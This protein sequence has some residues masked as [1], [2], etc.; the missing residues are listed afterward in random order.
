MEKITFGG[1]TLSRWK[2]GRS[3][4]LASPE[5][6][7]RLMNWS[8][9]L[10]DGSIRDVI[11]WPENADF[12][13]IAKVRG[14]NPIL[15]PFAGR[16]F[17]DGE[18]NFWRDAAGVRR[19]MPMHGFAR[20]GSF[21]LIRSDARGFA[22]RFLPSAEARAAYPFAYDLTV[23]YRFDAVSL[24]CE[25]ALLNRGTE[26]MPWSPGYHLYFTLPWAE[27]TQRSDYLIR[28]P[29]G[30]RTRQSATGAL[31]PQPAGPAEENLGNP[32]LIDLEFRELR[33][34]EV[35]FGEKGRPGDVVLRHGTADVPHPDATIITW[36]ET[37]TSPFYC[38]EPCMGPPNAPGT[39]V[40]LQWV[41]PGA[42]GLFSASI[43][44]K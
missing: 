40:G 11:Y 43:A 44:V 37:E 12:G 23:T 6:G 26:P 1:Q 28:I 4:F 39:K 25:L 2:V 14:G 36:S 3:T 22:A 7:A 33:S 13:N 16:S 8:L 19:P 27:G 32:E 17:D 21:E 42:T 41:K 10:G 24:S 34:A 35:V 29:A 20:Q 38:V 31:L 18:I 9:T 15:F 30:L 5:Q